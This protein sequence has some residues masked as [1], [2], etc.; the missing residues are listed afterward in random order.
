MEAK[1]WGRYV[2]ELMSEECLCGREKR[3]QYSFCY[4][5]YKLLPQDLQRRLY[6]RI[7]EGYEEAFEEAAKRLEEDV[8]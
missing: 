5:C 6:S 8:W 2:E 4:R 7:G 1:G 3:R